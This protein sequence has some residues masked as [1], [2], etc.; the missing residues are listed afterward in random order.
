MEYLTKSLFVFF[1]MLFNDSPNL[2]DCCQQVKDEEE[3]RGGGVASL[4]EGDGQ[5]EQEVTRKDQE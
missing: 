5:R 2:N 1:P 3:R 4:Y